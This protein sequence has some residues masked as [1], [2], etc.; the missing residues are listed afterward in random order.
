MLEKEL[1]ETFT[2][3]AFY[4]DG[5]TLEQY[6]SNKTSNYADIDRKNLAAFGISKAVE[7]SL[8]EFETTELIYRVFVEPNQNLIYRRRPKG[9]FQTGEVTSEL[10]LVGT[11]E[12]V[13]GVDV[14]NI[15]YIDVTTGLIQVAGKWVGGEPTMRSDEVGQ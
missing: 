14:Q 7:D 13:N 4:S 12:K 9:N 8:A 15:A 2:W 6:G 5:T 11:K 10:I 1:R 3:T